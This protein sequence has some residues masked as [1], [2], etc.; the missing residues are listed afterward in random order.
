MARDRP[1]R[2]PTGSPLEYEPQNELGVAYL[3]SHVARQLGLTVERVQDGFPDCI[4]YKAGRRVRIEFEYRSRNF[5]DHG[6]DP[7]GC[8]WIVCWIHDWP[9]VPPRLH[10]KE[11]RTYFGLGWDV[12]LQPL[13]PKWR[14]EVSRMNSGTWSVSRQ[15]KKGDL[16]LFYY[17]TPYRYVGDIVVVEEPLKRVRA[18]WK[19]GEDSMA[20]VR[21]VCSLKAPLHLQQLRRHPVLGNAGFV[22][23]SM[24]GRHKATEYWPELYQ[25]ILSLN[26][27]AREKLRGWAP[28]QVLR[29]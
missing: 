11:L 29:G 13:D 8:D 19:R 28:E 1:A 25:L 17:A 23:A 15:A 5:R 18:G 14:S 2:L 21:R 6:H 22:R 20:R 24:Q 26:P 4:A 16:V 27:G 7:R 9:D 10:V 3:F 12:W